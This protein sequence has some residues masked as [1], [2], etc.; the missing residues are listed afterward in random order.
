LAVN[1]VTSADS[2]DSVLAALA[3]MSVDPPRLWPDASTAEPF[4][5]PVPGRWADAS[6]RA[7]QEAG[8]VLYV[9]GGGFEQSNPALEHLMACHLSK[10]AGRP[11]FNLDYSLA[12][13][14]PFPAAHDEAVAA[15]RA[16]LAEGV[17]AGRT[18][19]FG[20]SA[21]ATILL[22]TLLTLRAAGVPLPGAVVPVSPVTD[23][24]LASPS[25]DA[26]AGRDVIN[27][28]VIEHVVGQYLDGQP[29]DQAP[30]SPIHGDLAGLP[31]M[32]L[33]AGGDEALLDDSRRYAEAAAEAAVEVTLDIYEGM[34][35][36][37]HVAVLPDPQPA[38]GALFLQ[39]LSTWLAEALPGD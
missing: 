25:I 28:K 5:L 3:G 2:F 16:L 13:A 4:P 37:F 6:G 7:P 15:Y 10:A 30:Q 20:E 9:H 11:A 14:H 19:M 29:N 17:P 32:L 12:P 33:V 22:E 23:F 31:R 27:R 36:A 1:R 18:V 26:P 21:G 24:T 8:V 35:H 38:V 39:R 34:P